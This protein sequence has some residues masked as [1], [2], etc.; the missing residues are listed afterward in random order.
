MLLYL[1]ALHDYDKSGQLDGLEFLRLLSEVLAWQPQGRPA[2]DAVG[3]R[4]AEQLH[5]DQGAA[6]WDRTGPDPVAPSR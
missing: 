4:G 3:A 2:P 1:F 6:P 5:Q